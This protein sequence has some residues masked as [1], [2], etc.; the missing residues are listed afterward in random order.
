MHGTGVVFDSSAMGNATAINYVAL[1]QGSLKNKISPGA[2]AGKSFN[3]PRMR[4]Q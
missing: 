1:R 4:E 3:G 2:R